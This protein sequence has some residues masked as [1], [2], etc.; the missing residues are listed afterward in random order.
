MM[1]RLTLLNRGAGGCDV[2]SRL[3][4]HNADAVPVIGTRRLASRL[5]R[6]EQRC[7][8]TR[9][10]QCRCRAVAS[11][12]GNAQRV[13]GWRC[14]WAGSVLR[15]SHSKPSVL[16]CWHRQRPPSGCHPRAGCRSRRCRARW[17]GDSAACWPPVSPGWPFRSTRSASTFYDVCTR[18]ARPPSGQRHGAAAEPAAAV[19]AS[20]LGPPPALPPSETAKTPRLSW[21]LGG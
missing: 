20:P 8:S 18:C 5:Q 21:R 3:D 10:C 19:A 6:C 12:I 9:E 13:M 16:R 1:A 14:R 11:A 17:P 15:C 7:R 4:R 2:S